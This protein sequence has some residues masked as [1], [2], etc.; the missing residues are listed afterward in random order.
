LGPGFKGSEK[1]VIKMALLEVTNLR[2]EF[3]GVIANDNVSLRVEKGEIIG[4][5]GPNGA[6]KTT[7]FNCIVGYLKPDK[8][9]VRFKD[10]DITALKPFQTNRKGIART[11]QL[12]KVI[13][14]LTVLGNTYRYSEDDRV[15]QSVSY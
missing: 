3:G 4:L 15:S 2:K 10:E 5:I 11:F 8:G 12:M 13:A 1:E 7:L 14:D 6:G 9:R